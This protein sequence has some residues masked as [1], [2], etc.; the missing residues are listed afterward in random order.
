MLNANNSQLLFDHLLHHEEA[1]KAFYSESLSKEEKED[2]ISLD[3]FYSMEYAKIIGIPFYKG[4]SSIAKDAKLSTLYAVD[5]VRDRFILGEKSVSKNPRFSC[6][7]SLLVMKGK[8]N[9]LIHR[10]MIETGIR[11][12]NDYWV[13]QYFR[14]MEHISG[15]CDPPFWVLSNRLDWFA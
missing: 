12:P 6:V 2:A 4:E 9:D 15:N 11:K 10:S 8:K 14:Y 5:I 3:S 13:K 7:Y 1:K